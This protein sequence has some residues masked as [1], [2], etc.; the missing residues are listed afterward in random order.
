MTEHAG[1]PTFLERIAGGEI[2]IS[3]GATGTYLQ[4]NGLE[5][6]GCPEAFNATHP[7][8]VRGMARSYFDAGSDLVL[9]NTFGGNVFM[10]KKYGHGQFIKE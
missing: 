7:E 10:Q 9:T 6:G 2:L 5:P 8:V 3:D 4:V 1:T